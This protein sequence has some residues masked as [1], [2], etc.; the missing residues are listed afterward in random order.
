MTSSTKTRI[1]LSTLAAA[2]TLIVAY[3]V[4]YPSQIATKTQARVVPE[5]PQTARRIL[6]KTPLLYEGEY[7]ENLLDR[8]RPA[9]V[10]ARPD[11]DDYGLATT[12]FVVDNDGSVLVSLVSAAQK[13]HVRTASGDVAEGELAGVDAIHGL[14]LLRTKLPGPHV[15]MPIATDVPLASVEPLIGMQASA[16]GGEVRLLAKAVSASSYDEMLDDASLRPGEMALDTD[17]RVRAFGAE[18]EDGPAPLHAYELADIVKALATS[19]RHQHPFLGVQLQTVDGPLRA[20]FADGA[21]VTVYVEPDSPADRAGFKPGM[22]FVEVRAGDRTAHTREGVD[23]ILEVGQTIEFEPVPAPRQK[24]P[25]EPVSVTVEDRQEPLP[26]G[27]HDLGSFGLMASEA[28]PGVEIVVAPGGEA[29]AHGLVTGDVV[30]AVDLRPVTSVRTLQRALLARP[31]HDAHLV[32]VRRGRD[33][34]FTLLQPAAAASV[35]TRTRHE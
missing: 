21:L 1:F 10:S 9:L 4:W 17:G 15:T 3:D 23:N 2:V 13:W 11:P 24:T 35:T 8:L 31:A 18:T 22:A 7:L 27:T 5:A 32:T 14:A 29:A 26:V 19:G 25:P 28:Q 30:E 16:T 34:F 33:R 12:G 20:Y 6:D